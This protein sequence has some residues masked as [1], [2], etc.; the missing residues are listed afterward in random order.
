MR[1]TTFS[2]PGFQ[3]LTVDAERRMDG[4]AYVTYCGE[5][6][7]LLALG[8]VTT[9]AIAV[10]PSGKPNPAQRDVFGSPV[11][12]TR[13]YVAGTRTIRRLEVHHARVDIRDIVKYPGAT[14]ALA[15]TDAVERVRLQFFSAPDDPPAIAPRRGPYLIVDNGRLP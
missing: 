3:S 12:I 7:E 2:V 4:S 9:A 10:G 6:S 1:T 13:H 8:L 15:A 11:R 14:A 5:P